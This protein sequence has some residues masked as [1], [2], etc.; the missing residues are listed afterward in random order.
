MDGKQLIYAAVAG[1]M[2]NCCP[3]KDAHTLFNPP[4]INH[5]QAQDLKGTFY[6]VGV[7]VGMTAAGLAIG[8]VVVN[9]PADR[10]GIQPNDVITEIDGRSVLGLSTGAAVRAIDGPRA[11]AVTL[12]IARPGRSQPLIVRVVRDS[13]P[14]VIFSSAGNVA[15]IQ[16]SI[17][18]SDTAE[19]V[20]SALQRMVSSH[21][22]NLILD[23]RGN[24]G[25]YVDAAQALASEFLPQGAVIFWQ[26]TN[27]GDDRYSEVPQVVAHQ[28]IGRHLRIVVLVD[29]GPGGT[30]SAAEILAAALRENGRATIL[31]ATTYGKGSEQEYLTLQDGSAL[32]ITT[33]LW[34]TPK[35]H[36]I[37][38]I[39]ITPDI[40]IDRTSTPDDAQIR[41][42]R[43]YLLKGR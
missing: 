14:N 3:G 26:R 2:S 22:T 28:G 31:G 19:G 13:L 33:R 10:A 43:E 21:I 17:F 27:L 15:R 38:G 29:G 41:M 34:L 20:H 6:G 5:S 18:G 40:L 30:A 25:G 32:R 7:Q 24:G 42:A 16:F 37:N 1:M 9:S 8:A 4:A 39:G 12:T 35:R 23:L 36:Q 11:T